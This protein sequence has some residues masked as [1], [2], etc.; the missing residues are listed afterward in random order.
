MVIPAVVRQLNAVTRTRQIDR[1]DL[2]DRRRRTVGHHQHPIRE[3]DRF[4]NVVGDR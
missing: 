1:E 4:I 2:T 3:Q